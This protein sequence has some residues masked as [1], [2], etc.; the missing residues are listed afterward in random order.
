MGEHIHFKHMDN[1][2]STL[3]NPVS[4]FSSDQSLN[5]SVSS[6]NW[7][8]RNVGHPHNVEIFDFSTVR[9]PN[10]NQ[11]IWPDFTAGALF[12]LSS[13]YLLILQTK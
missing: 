6:L 3:L 10:L 11:R 8:E 5:I 9:V 13:R 4:M 2:N 12:T 7:K 1:C